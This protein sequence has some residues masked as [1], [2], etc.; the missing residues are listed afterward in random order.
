MSSESAA[1]NIQCS[2]L[3]YQGRW[4]FLWQINFDKIAQ[5]GF[6]CSESAIKLERN[7]FSCLLWSSNSRKIIAC[8]LWGSRVMAY[9]WIFW[10]RAF[11]KYFLSRQNNDLNL[12]KK[13][14]FS[15]IRLS[16]SLVAA[17]QQLY[18]TSQTAIKSLDEIWAREKF[19]CGGGN[20]SPD[21]SKPSQMKS[22]ILLQNG[23]W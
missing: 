10:A 18:N 22:K 6:Y 16:P 21:L 9:L 13:F 7:F 23:T 20:L 1:K 5:K 12:K 17:G 19:R 8:T 14:M 15:G 4:K 2:C 3:N 11:L